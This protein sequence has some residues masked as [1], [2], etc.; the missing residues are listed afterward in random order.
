M[1][2]PEIIGL[3][4]GLC[5]LGFV[6]CIAYYASALYPTNPFVKLKPLSPRELV[7]LGE[8]FPLY[9]RLP[10]KLKAHCNRRIIWFR[11]RKK[12]VFYGI[13]GDREE[14]RLLVSAAAVFLTLGLRNFK[15]TRSVRRLVVYP[16]QYYSSIKRRHHL[17]EYNPRLKCLVFAADTLLQGF[18]EPDD[19][20]NLALHELAHALSF[21]MARKGSWEARRFRV[22]MRK[23][24]Q[25]FE[26]PSFREQLI[27]TRYF[28][29]YGFTNLQE[30]LA[31]AVENYFETPSIFHRDFPELFAIMQHMLNFDFEIACI[32]RVHTDLD[33]N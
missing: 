7:F 5:F 11:S 30:F 23:M 26:K 9:N 19:N 4:A 20:S 2:I 32:F 31:V 16:S 1:G 33:D 14:V 22:G 3:L 10:E 15:F 12:F 18:E 13:K 29:H 28:R 8:I 25:L 27:A 24:K 17:G 21:E 6:L